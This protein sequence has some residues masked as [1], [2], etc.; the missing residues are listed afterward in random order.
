MIGQESISIRRQND[1][2]N[3]KENMSSETFQPQIVQSPDIDKNSFTCMRFFY[4][5]FQATE[6]R[7]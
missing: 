2:E 3:G 4:P 7:N 6:Q 1:R 5:Q